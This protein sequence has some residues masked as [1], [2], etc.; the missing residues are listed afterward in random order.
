[1]HTRMVF[2]VPGDSPLTVVRN[3]RCRT[4]ST[5]M[6]KGQHQTWDLRKGAGLFPCASF[7]HLFT[8]V[9]ADKM[10]SRLLLC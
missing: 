8:E 10:F 1:M 2:A 3:R 4:S 6:L 7:T 9:R 5:K